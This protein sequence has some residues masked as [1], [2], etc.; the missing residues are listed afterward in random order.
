MTNQ[1]PDPISLGGPERARRTMDGLE[2]FAG[3]LPGFRRAHARGVALRG[4]FTATPEAAALTTA[5][6][7]Q[8]D[9]VEAIVRLSNGASSPYAPDRSAVLGLGVRFTLPA[10]GVAFWGALNITSFPAQ[11]PDDFIKLTSA[12]RRSAKGKLNPL[13]VLVHIAGHF[14]TFGGLLAILRAQTR[15]S[16]AATS[17]NG[18]HAYHL[19]DADGHRQAFRYRWIPSQDRTGLSDEQERLF[20]PQYLLSEVA[21]RVQR[22]PI[23]WTLVF[24]LAED[25]DPTHDLTK[26]WPQERRT[27]TAGELVLDALHEDP[28]YVDGLNFDPTVVPPGIETSDDPI[29]H[30]RSA[31]YKESRERRL[32]ESKPEVEPG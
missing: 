26:Q 3:A 28:A 8:G 21:R 9:P 24:Q 15:P 22:A 1:R 32:G 7:M 13:R 6:H 23:A 25:G 14:G 11:K 17:F 4:Q 16:F 19:I 29:L 30:F 10:G 31:A 2:R 20:P 5:E 27:I 12:Q 18:L